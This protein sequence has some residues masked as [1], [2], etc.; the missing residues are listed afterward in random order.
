MSWGIYRFISRES[1]WRRGSLVAYSFLPFFFIRFMSFGPKACFESIFL[2]LA[3][4]GSAQQHWIYWRVIHKE[5]LGLMGLG[6]L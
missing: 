5:G 6:K 3:L 4:L 2:G 1:C